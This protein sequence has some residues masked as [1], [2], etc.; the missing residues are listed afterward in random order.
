M[1]FFFFCSLSAFASLHPDVTVLPCV[2]QCDNADYTHIRTLLAYA[3]SLP[4][5]NTASRRRRGVV[6]NQ[7]AASTHTHAHSQKQI[8]GQ[9]AGGEESSCAPA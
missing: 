9:T 3:E 2:R 1:A 4:E 5:G 6:E 7:K 8:H